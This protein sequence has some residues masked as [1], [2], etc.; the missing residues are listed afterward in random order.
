MIVPK[1]DK[2][3]H[4][5]ELI[6]T[7]NPIMEQAFKSGAGATYRACVFSLEFL[8][9]SLM[10]IFSDMARRFASLEVLDQ[11][12]IAKISFDG[13]QPLISN[14]H[15]EKPSATTFPFD[16][17]PS[18]ITGVDP[19]FLSGFL[20]RYAP[21]VLVAFIVSLISPLKLFQCV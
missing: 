10:V 13:P 16:M 15:V 20:A 4:L 11:E 2:M 21:I 17:S 9:L 18:F 8:T 14:V 6:L 3:I 12:A 1:K 5:R 7:G 19:G